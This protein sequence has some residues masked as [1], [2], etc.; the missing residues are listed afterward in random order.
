MQNVFAV[1]FHNYRFSRYFDPKNISA[2]NHIFEIV[3]N[4]EGF[5]SVQ[6]A[7][8]ALYL[9]HFVIILQFDKN[10][11]NASERPTILY[12]NVPKTILGCIAGPDFQYRARIGRFSKK[13]EASENIGDGHQTRKGSNF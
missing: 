10:A 7:I 8:F 3:S 13:I 6:E 2:K 5:S 4:L 1:I 12:P 9:Q 11:R